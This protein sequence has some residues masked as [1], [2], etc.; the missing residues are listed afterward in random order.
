MTESTFLDDQVHYWLKRD[1]IVSLN[2]SDIKTQ[3]LCEKNSISQHGHTCKGCLWS[4]ISL[5]GFSVLVSSEYEVWQTATTALCPVHL[6]IDMM[7]STSENIWSNINLA[8]CCS[9]AWHMTP[10]VISSS[11]NSE[12][13]AGWIHQCACLK[14]LLYSSTGCT[15]GVSIYGIH[16]NASVWENPYV[17]VHSL[18]LKYHSLHNI[19][20]L[21][22]NNYWKIIILKKSTK[23]WR[24]TICILLFVLLQTI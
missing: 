15:I 14:T 16:M 22:Q 10:N 17:C 6:Y 9:V 13:T 11:Q 1:H 2:A 12:C 18:H 4:S 19:T 3:T 21:Q 5:N 7:T 20:Q 24:C 8:A 23:L